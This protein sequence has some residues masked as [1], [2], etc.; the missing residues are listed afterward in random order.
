M[1]WQIRLDGLLESL[2]SVD[3]TIPNHFHWDGGQVPFWAILYDSVWLARK[4]VDL[5]VEQALKDGF[6]LAENIAAQ[7]QAAAEAEAEMLKASLAP[8]VP[9]KK[10]ADPPPAGDKPPAKPGAAP[11]PSPKAKQS[12]IYQ[13]FL[14]RTFDD[15]HPDG[16]FHRSCKL[17]R[18]NGGHAILLGGEKNP[19]EEFQVGEEI[20]WLDEAA[21]SELEVSVWDEDPNSPRYRQPEIWKLSGEHARGPLELHHTRII[22]LTGVPTG[23]RPTWKERHW[24]LSVLQPSLSAIFAYLEAMKGV[25]EGLARFD[26]GVLKSK[27]LF[28]AL[29]QLN[30]AEIDARQ[31]IF[32][33]G[34]KNSRTMMLDPEEEYERHPLNFGGLA[35]AV[36]LVRS[37]VAGSTGISEASIFGVTPGGLAS[38]GEVES[39]ALDDHVAMYREN[40]L[41][42]ALNRLMSALSGKEVKVDFVPGEGAKP[43]Q[44]GGKTGVAIKGTVGTKF[45]TTRRTAEPKA[46]EPDDSDSGGTK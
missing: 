32:N 40:Q 2:K 46:K 11:A 13:L 25:K 6:D 23:K 45:S 26:V 4:I 12:E 1:S 34:V 36:G 28:D 18:L 16:I 10:D 7:E 22:L 29:D 9:P 35:D 44:A 19:L 21:R 41:I 3:H 17:G 5:P 24:S 15:V 27:G 42:P 43:E 20:I 31:K 39:D 14:D 33:A 37:D 8:A 38:S 30:K